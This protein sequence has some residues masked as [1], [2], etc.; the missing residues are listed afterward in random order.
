[1]IEYKRRANKIINKQSVIFE[2]IIVLIYYYYYNVFYCKKD[3]KGSLWV[4][5]TS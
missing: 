2:F 3:P 1:M 4:L 5:Q